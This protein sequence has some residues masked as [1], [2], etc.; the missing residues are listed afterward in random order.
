MKPFCAI[1]S[2]FLQRAYDQVIHDVAVQHLPVR[3]A[4]DR[5]GY[6]GA[7]G[8]TH[9]GNYDPAYLGTIPGMVVMAAGD[10][11]ELRHMVRTAAAYDDG[12]IAFRYPRA[13]G[14]GVDL[15]ERGSI[16]EIGRG[17][18][19]REGTSVALLC[20]GARLGEVARRGREARGLRALDHGR[21]RALHEAA[22]H[23]SD[24]PPR[25]RARGAADHRGRRRRRL[26]QPRRD[27]ARAE[28]A[29]STAS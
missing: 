25:P 19:L 27:L 8:P 11:A 1:Y 6:V 28:R 14:L 22:R 7:D 16:L 23:R 9:A 12:P 21:R 26:R 13:E 24:R 10:E 2:T 20:Y 29:C 17:R 15:P 4:I 5:A 3:F 18:V